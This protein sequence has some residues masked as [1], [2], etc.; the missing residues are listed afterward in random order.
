MLKGDFLTVILTALFALPVIM[1]FFITLSREKI[2][3]SL[4]SLLSGVELIVALYL[5]IYLTRGIFFQ[6]DAGPFA[7][8]YAWIP[9]NIKSLVAGQDIVVYLVFVPLILLLLHGLLRLITHPIDTVVLGVLANGL[10]KVI[11]LV[12]SWFGRIIG[13]LAQIPRAAMLVFVSALLLHFSSYYFPSQTLTQMMAKSYGYQLIYKHAVSPV[14]NS[15]LAQKIPVLVNDYFKQNTGRNLQ[16]NTQ[17]NTVAD[18]A[19]V[20]VITYF[21]GATLDEAVKSNQNIDA[22][23][24]QV[25]GSEQNSRQQAYFIYRWITKNITYDDE[26]A[27]QVSQAASGIDSGAIIAF[28]TRSGVCFDYASLYIAMCRA[29]GLKVRLVTGL[30][31]SGSAWGDHAWNQVYMPEE[32]RWI[33]VDATFGTV[34]NYFD[35]PDFNV[36]H[37]DAIVQGEWES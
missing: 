30:G 14:L 2:H 3:S 33:D 10:N 5:A 34:L 36:D 26:K 32:D 35:K 17:E 31:Y 12:G 29:V 25:V 37:K 13:A 11:T 15:N 23:A 27:V 6:H 7:T 4:R 9:E 24:R 22:T 19:K 18:S 8:I 16:G 21:N 28:D 1:G 20:R